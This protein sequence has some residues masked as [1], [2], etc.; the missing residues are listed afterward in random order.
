MWLLRYQN[1]LASGQILDVSRCIKRSTNYTI[2]RSGKCTFPIK[3]DKSISR[4]HISIEWEGDTV[5]IINSGKLTAINGEYKK[6]S[7]LF[8]C[9]IADNLD[10]SKS[11]NSTS[12]QINISLGVSPI[13]VT[14]TWIPL[15]VLIPKKVDIHQFD[16]LEEYGTQ[17][18]E[19]ASVSSNLLENINT[20]LFIDDLTDSKYYRELF[21]YTNGIHNMTLSELQNLQTWMEVKNI[22][23]DEKWRNE[24][25]FDLFEIVNNNNDDDLNE[26]RKIAE[27][28]NFILIGKTDE[29]NK[30][31]L[32]NAIRKIH[33]TT[34]SYENIKDL[35]ESLPRENFGERIIV[36]KLAETQNLEILQSSNINIINI[37]NFVKH[38]R[39]KKLDE[40]I[41]PLS[42]I[43]LAF[44]SYEK[45]EQQTN[46]PIISENDDKPTTIHRI[47]ESQEP[48]P[49][50]TKRRRITRPKIKPLNSL[51]FFAGGG[52]LSGEGK[53]EV[54]MPIVDETK[55]PANKDVIQTKISKLNTTSTDETMSENLDKSKSKIPMEPNSFAGI[56]KP[57]EGQLNIETND[58]FTKT[59]NDPKHS[60]IIEEESIPMGAFKNI[61]ENSSSLAKHRSEE[62]VTSMP[63]SLDSNRALMERPRTL[64]DVIQSTKSKEVERLKTNIVEVRPEELTEGALN[65]FAN[66]EIEE[67]PSLIVRRDEP[68]S[69]AT[70]GPWQGRK[71]FKKFVKVSR[72]SRSGNDSITN[73]AYLITRSYIDTKSYDG[74]PRKSATEICDHIGETRNDSI[75]DKSLDSNGGESI[76][77]LRNSKYEGE[78]YTPQCTVP[79]NNNMDNSDSEN[80]S[81]SF[82]FSRSNNS[83]NALFVTN[84]EEEEEE[85]VRDQVNNSNLTTSITPVRTP[86]SS[87]V[88]KLASTIDVSDS[89]S[90]DSDDGPNFKFRRMA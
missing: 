87:R 79:Q 3:N 36:I 69:E 28:V 42:N 83:S 54:T 43:K 82:S 37:D 19:E 30:L 27:T 46:D 62:K 15:N 88:Q 52:D 17:Y 8:A 53:E 48:N 66:L 76:N 71:N 75:E 74:K 49:M 78:G 80:E 58:I 2:G 22:N 4:N 67:N 1:T 70:L 31:Y 89:D 81:N 23:F 59:N 29:T 20:V 64:V 7:E 26:I 90:D 6:E 47:S 13:E 16:Q 40:F 35:K 10:L 21:T 5:N 24:M 68:H 86:A 85:N 14:L 63:V 77:T 39:S 34:K 12:Q 61:V 32:D 25:K 55:S 45:A 56:D 84:E 73:N 18:V 51:S 9:S 41:T 11:N 33:G 50:P 60:T 57:N 72:S 38:L 44:I 65:E